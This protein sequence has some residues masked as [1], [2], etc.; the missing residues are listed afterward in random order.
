M[1]LI[2]VGTASRHCAHDRYGRPGEFE[3]KKNLT[4]MQL[5]AFVSTLRQRQ[6]VSERGSLSMGPTDRKSWYSPHGLPPVIGSWRRGGNPRTG[7]AQD[8]TQNIQTMQTG[9]EHMVKSYLAFASCGRTLEIRFNVP[10]SVCG[11]SILPS[12]HFLGAIRFQ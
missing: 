12:G 9:G 3:L 8:T 5:K 6:Q 10:A 4:E 2:P 1:P 7:P 11:S